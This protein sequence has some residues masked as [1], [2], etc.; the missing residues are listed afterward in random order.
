MPKSLKALIDRHIQ[1]AELMR[2]AASTAAPPCL[3]LSRLP[4]SGGED[5]GRRVAERLG[6]EF[7]GIELVDRIAREAGVRRKLVEALDE[8]VRMAAERY[9]ADCFQ[10]AVFRES[11]YARALVQTIAGIGEHGGAVLLGRGAPYVLRPERTLRVLLV[12][13]QDVRL[14]R[15][16]E[17]RGIEPGAAEER[18]AHEERER[19]EFLRHHFKVDPDDPALY[20]VTLNT[21]TLGAEGAEALLLRAFEQRFPAGSTRSARA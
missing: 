17:S 10:D 15:L 20:D 18:L 4:G 1:R 13:P 7:Y 16:A 3:A 11:D 21:A 5:L 2:R 14:A 12:A 9:A 8:H 6:Y 19:R